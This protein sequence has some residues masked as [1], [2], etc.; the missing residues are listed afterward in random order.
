MREL[1]GHA[2]TRRP[3]AAAA[4]TPPIELA[5]LDP[6]GQHGSIGFEA[7]TYHLQTE[8]VEAAERAEIRAHEGS[9]KH[10]EVF[11]MGSV[12]TP[13]IGRPRPSPSDR[14]AEN[15]TLICEEPV[16]V[17]ERFT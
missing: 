12:R 11:Q 6:A 7:L 2:V 14:R 10:V 4:P 15:Y 1:A 17:A 3:L 8:L 9:V 5:R 13:I 16:N